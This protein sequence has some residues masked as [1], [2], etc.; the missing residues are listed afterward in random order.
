MRFDIPLSSESP[1]YHPP[2]S[3]GYPISNPEY[4]DGVV[5]GEG[6]PAAGACT[7]RGA[8]PV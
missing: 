5:D 8:L 3:F 2:M 6:E 4:K 1:S 7:R